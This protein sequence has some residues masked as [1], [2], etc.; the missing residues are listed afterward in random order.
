MWP[1]DV[2]S[3]PSRIMQNYDQCE[4]FVNDSF[5]QCVDESSVPWFCWK[6]R[7]HWLESTEWTADGTTSRTPFALLDKGNSARIAVVLRVFR[8]CV[9]SMLLSFHAY[10]Q[11]QIWACEQNCSWA[12]LLWSSYS[13]QWAFLTDF[14]CDCMHRSHAPPAVVAL[15]HHNCTILA[16]RVINILVCWF[17]NVKQSS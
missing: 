11:G 15:S 6:K 7:W 16:C 12:R 2:H 8:S 17:L 10:D 9:K 3:V 13:L 5:I 14:T 1:V 4:T